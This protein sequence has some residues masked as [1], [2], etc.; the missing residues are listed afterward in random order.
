M[1]TGLKELLGRSAEDP[2]PQSADSDP[3]IV[4]YR[5]AYRPFIDANGW[6]TVDSWAT[7]ELETD[8]RL[9]V[10]RSEFRR[11]LDTDY[12]LGHYKLFPVD[13]NKRLRAAEWGVTNGTEAEARQQKQRREQQQASE[14]DRSADSPPISQAAWAEI[15]HTMANTDIDW[16]RDEPD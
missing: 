8:R 12:P 1:L 4:A 10:R 15:Q 5:L 9:P 11:R 7:V 14:S 2:K 13:E 6:E 3:L 16:K